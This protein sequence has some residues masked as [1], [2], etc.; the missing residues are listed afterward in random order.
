MAQLI[1]NEDTLIESVTTNLVAKGY[2]ATEVS[3][4]VTELTSIIF[5]EEG[6]DFISELIENEIENILYTGE[7]DDEEEIPSSDVDL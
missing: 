3:E 5:G 1:L 2:D 4:I 7:E 6:Q